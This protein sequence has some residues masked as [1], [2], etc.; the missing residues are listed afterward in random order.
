MSSLILN[1][2]ELYNE[3]LRYL[4]TYNSGSPASA[5]STDAKFIT[6][7][8]YLRML[9]Y[10]GWT[11]S[12]QEGTIVTDGVNWKYTLPEDFSSFEIPELVYTADESYGP[13]IER[14]R[15]QILD[16][17]THS[18][19]TNYP[20][21]FALNAAKYDKE[22]GSAWEL[23]LYPTPDT[24]Y[25]LHFFYK[26]FPQKLVDDDD[27]PMGGPDVS[28]CLLELCLA[29]AEAYKEEKRGVHSAVVAEILGGAQRMDTKRNTSNLGMEITGGSASPRGSV[30]EGNS[31]LD[32][33]GDVIV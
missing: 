7:R 16:E 14:S 2:S 22:T 23:W 17:R 28:D 1:F 30:I 4:G 15:Q 21:Y 29:Y 26:S 18:V 33:D 20:L 6:N 19:Y 24:E 3:V 27:I 25:K 9:S 5:D 11:F 31:L 13:V 12:K 10:Y 8:A 32:D